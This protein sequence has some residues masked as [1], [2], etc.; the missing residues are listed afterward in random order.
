MINK[1][2]RVNLFFIA[3]FVAASS[4]LVVSCGDD[5]VEGPKVTIT[6]K[7][8]SENQGGTTTEHSTAPGGEIE[9]PEGD[10]IKF[11]IKFAMGTNKLRNVLI[12]SQLDGSQN[13]YT[14][15]KV[16][17]MDKGWFN[18]KG[19]KALD[20][21]FYTNVGK[22]KETFKFSTLDSKGNGDEFTLSVKAKTVTPPT[23]PATENNSYVKKSATTFG[24]QKNAEYPSF[25]SVSLG[26]TMNVGTASANK[27]SVNL[28]F[29]YKSPNAGVGCPTGTTTGG[30]QY[31]TITTSGWS[32][33]PAAT[34]GTVSSAST[35]NDAWWKS[36]ED[37]IGT[38]KEVTALTVNDAV[39]FKVGTVT[40]A[41]IVVSIPTAD[42][43]TI[44]VQFIDRIPKS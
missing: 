9:A 15:L 2:K 39:F 36:G 14:V 31:G 27:G 24:V 12:E 16:E 19:G 40:Y 3:A 25:Y 7:L 1:M 13:V 28:A 20:T 26:K 11:S 6:Y 38:D 29:F 41:F 8:S 4:M 5:E 21:I 32:T 22:T 37:A 17:D 10:D 23:P 33:S 42:T 30:I 43:G 35:L 44:I 18:L 34:F